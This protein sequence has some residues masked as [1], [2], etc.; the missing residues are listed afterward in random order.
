MAQLLIRSA[1]QEDCRDIAHLC[2]Q[3]GYPTAPEDVA[4]RLRHILQF[5][6]GALF[7]A[8]IEGGVVGWIQVVTYPLPEM[9][10]HAELGGLVVNEA[11]R[12]QGVGSALMVRAEEWARTQG[13]LEVRIRSN[14]IRKRAHKFYKQAG[15]E[16]IKTQY[17]FR[18]PL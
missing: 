17:T 13:C 16:S 4:R 8:E 3:M 15:Y 11:H 12:G 10:L 9:D 18:K 6:H 5:E 2:G 7:V 1:R 14:I